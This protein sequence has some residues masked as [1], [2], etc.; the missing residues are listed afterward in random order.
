MI[1]SPMLQCAALDQHGGDRAAALLDARLDDDA[2]GQPG[3]RSA[4]LE[5]LGLQQD[6]LQQLIDALAG[7]RRYRHEDVLAA[8]LLGDDLVLG[9]L[10][11]HAIRV[12]IALVDLVDRDD[13]RHVGRARVLD[14][15]DGLRHDAVVGRHHQHHDVGG[16]CAPRARMAVKAAWPGVSRKVMTPRGVSTW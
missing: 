15:L 5:H 1:A 13:D 16:A 9:E 8:P 4:Q 3:A 6:R 14:R 11:A 2:R 7:A 12:G 10:G